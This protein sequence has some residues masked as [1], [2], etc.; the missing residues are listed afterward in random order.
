MEWKIGDI[1]DQRLGYGEALLKLG[2]EREDII[3]L[4]ADLQRSNKTYGFG[5]AFP[6]RFFDM[7]IAEAD[8]VSTAAGM[9]SLGY[10]VFP[11][12]FAMFVPGRCY[13]Q[14]RLQVAYAESNVKLIGVSAGLTIG[15]DGASH[16]SLDDVALMRQLPNMTVFV[17]CDVVQTYKAV[18]RA[19]EIQGPVYIR[20]SRYPVPVIYDN[21]YEFNIGVPDI[22]VDGKDIILFASGIMVDKALQAAT[23]LKDKGLDTAVVNVS[24]I[25]PI[26]ELIIK[27]LFSGKKLIVTLEEH[28][29]IGGLGSLLS[30]ILAEN[31]SNSPLLRIG[32]KDCFG[33]SGTAEDLLD[34]YCLTPPKI[35]SAVLTALKK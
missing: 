14:I 16:Q 6:D 35:V 4:D 34:Y 26:D 21:S 17:P 15:P 20:V 10:T 33:Q 28:S 5:E 3:V 2:R 12:S 19:A 13:D 31:P 11:T 9:S 32:V 7:G 27:K 25:K 23:L 29:I 18:L 24:T 22:I 1:V 30:E 8:M